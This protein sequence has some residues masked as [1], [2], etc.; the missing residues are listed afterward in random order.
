MSAGFA[1]A[2]ARMFTP[3]AMTR[4]LSVASPKIR[5]VRHL[6]RRAGRPPGPQHA[7]QVVLT[8]GRP[9]GFAER[10][11]VSVRHVRKG[12]RGD[13]RVGA[14][15]DAVQ[16]GTAD[17]VGLANAFGSLYSPVSPISRRPFR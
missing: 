7:P 13:A 5:P 6:E 16:R 9:V 17:V 2:S 14:Q 4:S 3:S 15:V 11:E 10:I 8:T 1:I 12:V